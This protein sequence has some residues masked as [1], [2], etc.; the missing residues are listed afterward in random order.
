MISYELNYASAS[1]TQWEVDTFQN[2]QSDISTPKLTSTEFD[3]ANG[4]QHELYIMPEM[5]YVN[6]KCVEDLGFL[7]S[8]CLAHSSTAKLSDQM[9]SGQFN[10]NVASYINSSSKSGWHR[11]IHVVK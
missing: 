10:I 3:V 7:H 5:N 1:T 4:Y 9:E 11:L 8:N 6:L 2:K